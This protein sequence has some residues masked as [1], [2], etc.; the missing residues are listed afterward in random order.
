[1]YGLSYIAAK[2]SF[3]YLEA[4]TAHSKWNFKPKG[5][6][7]EGLP[8]RDLEFPVRGAN[9]SNHSNFTNIQGAW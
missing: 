3:I 9:Y 2:L 7:D 1:L 5:P 8:D 6:L 4:L